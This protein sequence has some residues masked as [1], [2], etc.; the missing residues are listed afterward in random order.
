M[1]QVNQG[2]KEHGTTA[3]MGVRSHIQSSGQHALMRTG[4]KGAQPQNPAKKGDNDPKT[5]KGN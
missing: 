3:I 1:Y 4:G 5:N 2:A